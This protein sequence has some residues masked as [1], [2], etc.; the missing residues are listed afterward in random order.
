MSKKLLKGSLMTY[1]AV[2]ISGTAVTAAQAGVMG[3]STSIMAGLGSAGSWM[4]AGVVLTAKT[5]LDYRRYKKGEITK[6]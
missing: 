3:G 5:G 1:K 6:D 2:N 4:F